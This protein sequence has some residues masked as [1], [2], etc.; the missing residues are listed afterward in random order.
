[1]GS[2]LHLCN[3]LTISLSETQVWSMLN[4]YKFRLRLISIDWLC[5]ML[6]MLLTLHHFH[7]G[8]NQMDQKRGSK[9]EENANFP[10][11]HNF[12]N[13]NRI[14]KGWSATCSGG[15]KPRYFFSDTKPIGN[16]EGLGRF[17]VQ[18]Q[19]VSRKRKALD[20]PM[21]PPP[22]FAKS[23][24]MIGFNVEIYTLSPIFISWPWEKK[25]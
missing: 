11:Q 19:A 23:S 17:G 20:Y 8:A 3:P 4:L 25:L 22:I 2:W 6:R 7:H 24:A 16:K 5:E 9:R 14:A 18:L 12:A 15:G 10:Q 13:R 21:P 1:M